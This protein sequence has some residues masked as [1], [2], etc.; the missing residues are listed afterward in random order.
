VGLDSILSNSV[1]ILPFWGPYRCSWCSGVVMSTGIDKLIEH[2]CIA[3]RGLRTAAFSC[4]ACVGV[5]VLHWESFA[6][7][8]EKFHSSGTALAMVLNEACVHA[9]YGWGIAL[10]AVITTTS[11]LGVQ[12]QESE[13]PE[14]YVTPWGGY[15]GGRFNNAKRELTDRIKAAQETVLPEKLKRVAPQPSVAAKAPTQSRFFNQL[16]QFRSSASVA[17]SRPV[18]PVEPASRKRASASRAPSPYDPNQGCQG[19]TAGATFSVPAYKP[20]AGSLETP[21]HA[22]ADFSEQGTSGFGDMSA[23][24]PVTDPLEEAINSLPSD[25]TDG[26]TGMTD[27]ML[28]SSLL[29]SDPEDRV[30][31]RGGRMS[32]DDMGGD[33]FD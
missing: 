32:D 25:R 5:S 3:H 19:R 31:T 28:E 16:G 7:H 21:M 2:I 29:D 14:S 26:N 9:R 8:W 22:P 4:P 33:G 17:G 12:M 18:T 6:V 13:E 11:V 23:F 1:H 27:A 24:R 15:C 30:S 20:T 10:L